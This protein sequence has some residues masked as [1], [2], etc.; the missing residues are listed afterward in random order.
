MKQNM[1]AKD[2]PCTKNIERVNKIHPL[3]QNNKAVIWGLDDKMIMYGKKKQ[4]QKNTVVKVL[5]WHHFHVFI[6]NTSS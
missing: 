5:D 1:H 2:V 4:K 6:D 3:N